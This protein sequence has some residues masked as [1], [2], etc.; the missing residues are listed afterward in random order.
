MFVNKIDALH[1][2]VLSL[3]FKDTSLARASQYPHIQ[4]MVSQS[5]KK[6]IESP[7]AIPKKRAPGVRACDWNNCDEDGDF[8]TAK[9]PRDM[10]DHVWYCE[11][12]IRTH[13]KAW[14][15]FEG[16][17]DDAVEAIIKNDTVWQRP[18]WKLGSKT[19]AQKAQTFARGARIRDDFGV[20][21]EDADPRTPHH[22]PRSFPPD[23]PVAKAFATLDLTPPL[24]VDD[25][26]ARYKK[27][28]RRHHPDTNDGCKKSEELFKEVGHAYQVVLKF[29]QD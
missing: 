17:D 24:T 29:L 28:A 10:A 27:L 9:S 22:L 19:E 4:A 5:R 21:N 26:K 14:N 13:N 8:R 20:L 3:F 12:H 16:L 2:S 11:D 25:A 1:V 6:G 15:Y 23:S 7:F 18:T